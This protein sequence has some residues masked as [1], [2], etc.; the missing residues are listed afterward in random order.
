MNQMIDWVCLNAKVYD[1][2]F[3]NLL[4]DCQEKVLEH[5]STEPL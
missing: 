3:M 5:I 1:T 2:I 4:M